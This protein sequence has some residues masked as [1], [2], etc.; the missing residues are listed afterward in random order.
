MIA[1]IVV[2]TV[3]VLTIAIIARALLSWFPNVNPYNP[4]VQF[5]ISITEPI[6]API[7]SIMPRIGFIDLTPMIAIILLQVIGQVLV[8]NLS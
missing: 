4:I 3:Y 1:E 8:S 7:R 2:I 6:L 5:I